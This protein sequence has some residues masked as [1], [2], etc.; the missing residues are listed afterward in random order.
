M[1]TTR[2]NE[3]ALGLIAAP[4]V[5]LGLW[6]AQGTLD[7]P[8]EAGQ[9]TSIATATTATSAET[10]ETGAAAAQDESRVPAAAPALE[11]A[12][13]ATPAA[14]APPEEE[15]ESLQRRLTSAIE[16]SLS[17]AIDPSAIV[18]AAISLLDLDVDK[19]NLPSTA[20]DGSLRYALKPCPEG[21]R[22]ELWVARSSGSTFENV[23]ALRVQLDAPTEPYVLEGAARKNA[24]AHVQVFVDEAGRMQ[25]LVL[26]TDVAP[27]GRSRSFGLPLDEGRIPQGILFHS[28]LDRPEE[29]KAEAYGLEDG[30]DRSF[31]DPVALLGEPWPD[32]T[33][34][35]ELGSGLLGLM[36]EARR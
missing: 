7:T 13:T 6:I 29:W 4:I 33:A 18:S 27:S 9:E 34:I 8:P 28:D 2:R 25:D 17:G 16:L 21:L 12:E 3:L 20:P 5:A 14:A 15:R 10:V 26:L 11:A 31:Q 1:D 30:R 23:L 19:S 36:S 24:V 35:A 22:A 32:P